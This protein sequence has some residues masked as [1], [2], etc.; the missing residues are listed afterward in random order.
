MISKQCSALAMLHLD[1]FKDEDNRSDDIDNNKIFYM[2]SNF[3]S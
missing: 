1:Q 2:Y 3:I